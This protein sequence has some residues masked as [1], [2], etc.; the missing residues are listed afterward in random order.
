LVS[1][2]QEVNDLRVAAAAAAGAV[3]LLSN[4]DAIKRS[5]KREGNLREKIRPSRFEN[6]V[7]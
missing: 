7:K 3:V 6:E 1:G 2:Y 5:K 4:A